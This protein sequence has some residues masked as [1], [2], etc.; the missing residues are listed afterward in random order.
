MPQLQT[1][2]ANSEEECLRP[3]LNHTQ[4]GNNIN[5]INYINN[6]NNIINIILFQLDITILQM[7]EIV[8][9]SVVRKKGDESFR[10]MPSWVWVWDRT[11][12]LS[13]RRCVCYQ[14]A[15]PHPLIH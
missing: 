13:H 3:N 7:N 2:P 11:Q 8:F 5:Y 6:N 14:C 10:K 12:V 1:T 9:K 4:T 15:T